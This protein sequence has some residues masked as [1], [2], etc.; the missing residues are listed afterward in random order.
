MHSSTARKCYAVIHRACRQTSS[1]GVCL[2]SPSS[3]VLLPEK[4][5]ANDKYDGGSTPDKRCRRYRNLARRTDEGVVSLSRLPT[6]PHVGPLHRG[7]PYASRV[8]HK[9]HLWR[10]RF[11]A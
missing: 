9:H 6:G 5:D 7:K 4:G 11:I 2:L 8:R 10:K 1:T 3:S